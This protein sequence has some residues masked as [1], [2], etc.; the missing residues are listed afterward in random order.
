LNQEYPAAKI[1]I[2]KLSVPKRKCPDLHD[3]NEFYYLSS[4]L[5]DKSPSIKAAQ[6]E[7]IQEA[8]QICNIHIRI[9]RNKFFKRANGLFEDFED[10]KKKTQL[11]IS[12][13]LKQRDTVEG[14]QKKRLLLKKELDKKYFTEMRALDR[15]PQVDLCNE[16][17]KILAEIN[18]KIKSQRVDLML[19]EFVDKADGKK[20]T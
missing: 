16:V 20:I 14:L 1:P 12:E 8:I 11:I 3:I 18:A 7:K 2:L 9:Q 13:Y 4:L 5:D 19:K 17:N 10:W 6:P 15:I